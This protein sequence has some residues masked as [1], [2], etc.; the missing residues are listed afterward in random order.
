MEL[1]S[2]FLAMWKVSSL[3]AL[4]IVLN[5]CVLSIDGVVSE[6]D[7]NFDPRLLGGWE[8]A[9]GSDRAMVSRAAENKY[10]IEYTS[11]NGKVGKFEARLGRLGERLVLDVW[12]APRETDL[13]APYADML[14]EGHLL[15]AL[16]VSTNE[17]SFAM[18]EP[19][20]LRAALRAGAVRLA[21]GGPG[22][23]LILQGT[24]AELRSTLG[25]Y[26]ARSG[27]LMKPDVWRRARIQPGAAA[28][29]LPVEVPC[30]EV[31]SWHEADLLFRRD[32]HW[33]GADGASSVDLGGGRTLWL[34][35]DSWIDPSGRHTRQGARM[36]SNSVAVQT[37]TDP[38]NSS[39]AFYWGRTSD[40]SSA[41]LF[42][43]RGGERLWLGNGV[44]VGDRLVLFFNRI[45][46][47]NTGLGFE[48]LGWT[49]VMV[50]NADAEPSAWR[51]VPLETPT[52]PLGVIV[53]Y[54]AVLRL[55]EYVYAFGSEDPVKSHPVYVVR[56]R[57]RR[58]VAETCFS[59][60]G[61]RE[62]HSGGFPI[63]QAHGGGQ[64]SRT[65]NRT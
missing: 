49:A 4:S 6:S 50:D 45:H 29:A 42:P 28:R 43:D 47:T 22:D 11:D 18:L 46:S 9:S 58:F 51:V 53:G 30:F 36:I 16:E 60:S 65:A 54:A 34:F 59:R 44:R 40:G 10:A 64:C 61:G 8:E 63:H 21:Y 41:P 15:L 5:G 31:S 20:S 32:P 39:I 52:N 57:R 38:A 7:A 56:G 27:A 48:S 3:L 55:E 24:T 25:R 14:V 17:I 19:D 2:K 13:P 1:T 37:G 23:R 35:G 12:P 62:N 26:L 33:V